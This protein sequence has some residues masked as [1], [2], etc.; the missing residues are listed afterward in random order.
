MWRLPSLAS[1]M[2]VQSN[3]QNSR[4]L[5]NPSKNHGSPAGLYSSKNPTN[6]TNRW[7][8]ADYT[9]QSVV[10]FGFIGPKTRHGNP[11]NRPTTIYHS[12]ASVSASWSSGSSGRRTLR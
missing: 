6:P 11:T 12:P 1:I 8:A 4:E 9:K 7:Q 2:Q 10:G 5:P 3:E